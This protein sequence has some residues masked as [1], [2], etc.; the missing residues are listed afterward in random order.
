[1]SVIGVQSEMQWTTALAVHFARGVELKFCGTANI[2]GLWD[3]AFTLLHEGSFDTESVIS[4][5]L[6]LDDAL[7]GYALLQAGDAL[8]VLLRP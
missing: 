6:A 7:E 1:V 4:H 3:R 2:V 5:V 8:K